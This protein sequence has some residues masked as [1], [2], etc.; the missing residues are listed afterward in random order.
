MPAALSAQFPVADGGVVHLTFDHEVRYCVDRRSSAAG[1]D[2]DNAV[3]DVNAVDAVKRVYT[4]SIK[5]WDASLTTVKKV[6]ADAIQ[7]L[8]PHQRG[9]SGILDLHHTY[10]MGRVIIGDDKP[11][12]RVTSGE[13]DA[14]TASYDFDVMKLLTEMSDGG[15]REQSGQVYRL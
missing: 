5:L 3:N 14:H 12:V 15:A 9:G 4:A 6:Y 7:P 8:A 1:S 10:P 2:V 13:C 11:V